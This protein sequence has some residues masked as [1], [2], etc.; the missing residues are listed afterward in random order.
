MQSESHYYSGILASA[1]TILKVENRAAVSSV[2][3]N[4]KTEKSIVIILALKLHLQL[5]IFLIMASDQFLQ[6]NCG[7]DVVVNGKFVKYLK[8][9]WG[10]AY[11]NII[12]DPRKEPNAALSLHINYVKGK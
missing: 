12:I 5:I 2:E 11:G 10:I 4:F 8:G 6:E 1:I 7:P 3:C 9:S